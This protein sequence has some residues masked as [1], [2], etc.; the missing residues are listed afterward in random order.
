MAELA[1]KSGRCLCG[2]ARF[3]AKV[4][5]DVDVCHCG[6]CRRWSGGVFMAAHAEDVSIEDDSSIGAYRSSDYGERVFCKTCG[7]SLFW[8]MQDG[9]S[10]HVAVSAL[11]DMSGLAFANQIFID[12]KPSLYDFANST[13]TMTGA[14][15]VAMVEAGQEQA[16]G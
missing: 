5:R 4:S 15:F 6:M 11:D 13:R 16:G 7:S 1:Q 14:E 10:A 12:E 9:S 2:A 8:R 3:A